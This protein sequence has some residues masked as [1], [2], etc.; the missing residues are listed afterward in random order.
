MSEPGGLD[1]QAIRT[2]LAKEAHEAN[3]QRQ[4]CGTADAAAGDLANRD[5]IALH[6]RAID[7]DAPKLVHEHSPATICWT[8]GEQIENCGRLADPE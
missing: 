3:P 5:P 4:T 2:N 7:P 8:M 1:E 6:Q